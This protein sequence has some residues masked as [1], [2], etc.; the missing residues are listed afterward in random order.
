MDSR[1]RSGIRLRW[2]AFA[3]LFVVRK[4][5]LAYDC[6][7]GPEPACEP[8]RSR[9]IV[10]IFRVHACGIEPSQNGETVGEYNATSAYALYAAGYG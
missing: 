7:I 2:P 9:D 5:S 3:R 10:A 8:D 1:G 6:F 4:V